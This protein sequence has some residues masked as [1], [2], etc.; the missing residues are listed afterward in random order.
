MSKIAIDVMGGDNAPVEI[1]KGCIDALPEVDSTLVLVGKE[2]IIKEELK[3]YT[4][5]SSKIEIK[6]ATETIEMCE[7]PVT[8]V[9]TKKDSSMV[10]ALNLVKNNEVDGMVSAGSSGAL[11][12][13]ATFVVGRIKGVA[14]PAL[15]PFI[16][17]KKG[18]SLLIDAGANVDC[19]PEYLVQFARMGTVYVRQSKNIQNPKVGLVNI[20]AESEKGNQ[21]TKEAYQ[22]LSE[23]KDINFVGNLE[24]RDIPDGEIDII[25]CDGF[26]GNVIL[27]FM[28]GFGSWIKNLLVGEF[29]KNILTMAAAG[30]M[31]SAIKKLT[32]LF[33]VA[34]KGGAPFLGVKGLV[35]KTHGSSKAAEVKAT[36]IQTDGF[37]KVKLIENLKKEFE[38]EN[39]K[40]AKTN[41]VAQEN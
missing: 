17:T 24:P 19:K 29:K 3:K 25:V 26:T 11:L 10:V 9:R 22:L 38:K 39:A 4:Y 37:I 13:G 20:G 7:S 15:A 41:Q 30:L 1:I 21:L 2:D 23:S 16:P 5:D 34:K 8:A 33:A 35:V 14:R 18:S 40:I 28:E 36:I 31:H 27:K 32:G 6:N 12:T